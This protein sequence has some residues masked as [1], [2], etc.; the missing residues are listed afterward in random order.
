MPE[1]L[2]QFSIITPT[3]SVVGAICGIYIK[4]YVSNLNIKKQ[5]EKSIHV[6]ISSCLEFIKNRKIKEQLNNNKDKYLILP[7]FSD[8]DL[9][10]YMQIYKS[11]LDKIGLSNNCELYLLFYSYFLQ[12]R[13]NIGRIEQ[14][15]DILNTLTSKDDRE[16]KNLSQD[17]YK[18]TIRY[19]DEMFEIAEKLKISSLHKCLKSKIIE[20]EVIQA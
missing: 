10:H 20:P 11:N 15:K 6:E 13:K 19:V 5:L 9:E 17:F 12:L 18:N 1:G 16:Y 14:Q 4:E 8:D 3:I 7:Y 2:N